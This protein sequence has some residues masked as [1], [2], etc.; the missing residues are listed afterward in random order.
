MRWRGSIGAITLS[1]TLAC[2]A[3][4]ALAW[5]DAKYPDLS[6][7]WRR[8]GNGGLLAGGAGGLRWDDSLPP[9]NTPSLGQQPPLTPEYQA[10]YDANLADMTQGRQG[11]DASIRPTTAFRPACGAS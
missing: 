3:P 2:T 8:A 10:I 11:I 7:Q 1:V 4:G 5:D 9:K 6:G